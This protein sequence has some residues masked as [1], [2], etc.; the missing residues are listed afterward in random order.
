MWDVEG[1]RSAGEHDERERGLGGVKS[2]GAAGDQADLVVERFGSSLVDLE[3]DRGEDPIAVLADRLVESNERFEAAAGKARQE[4]VDQ[5]SDVVEGEAVLEDP[6]GCFCEG[7][8]APCLA[9]GGLEP[10]E[11]RGL[12]VGE[13]RGCFEQ[14]P[15]RVFEALGGVLV[16]EGSQLVSVAAS[17]LVQC[18]VRELDDVVGVD[19]HGRLRRVV[20]SGFRVPGGPCPSR[21]PG[22]VRRAPRTHGSRSCM[23]GS[24]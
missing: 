6:A 16:A 1:D 10:S 4:P 18:L 8:A 21:S 14:R 17:D 11:R 23:S 13:V 2:V 20:A 12:L 15:A 7:V 5:H 3:T 9:A 22:A 24:G 19:A